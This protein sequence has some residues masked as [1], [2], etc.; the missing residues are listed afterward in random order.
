MACLNR[1]LHHSAHGV[2]LNTLISIWEHHMRIIISHTWRRV[3]ALFRTTHALSDCEPTWARTTG[4]IQTSMRLKSRTLSLQ[5]ERFENSNLRL[6]CHVH[7]L[8]K[9]SG[10]NTQ[11]TVM[12]LCMQTSIHLDARWSLTSPLRSARRTQQKELREYTYANAK[13]GTPFLS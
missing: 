13:A 12:Q 11:Q 1:Q 7:L 4:P 10:T 2:C 9:R 5:H 3:I 8:Q 6:H